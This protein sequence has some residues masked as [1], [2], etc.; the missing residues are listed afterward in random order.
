MAKRKIEF[1]DFM[2]ETERLLLEKGYE[3]FH[4]KL[5][6]DRLNVARSTIYEYYA[7]KEELVTAY[8]LNIMNWITAES[9]ALESSIS[10]LQQLKSLMHIFIKY[11]QIHQISQMIPLINRSSSPAVKSSI[12]RLSEEHEK[13]YQMITHLIEKAKDAGEIRPDIPSSVLARFYFTAIDIPNN[14]ALTDR[15]WSDMIFLVL[16]EG[17][18]GS[19]GS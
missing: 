1:Q 16:Y 18:K 3:S 15:D 9:N 8:M 4:F 7:N 2:N 10:P 13:L 12:D 5:L 14:E 19:K 6:A 17:M 11:S